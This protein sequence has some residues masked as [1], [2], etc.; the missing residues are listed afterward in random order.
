MGKVKLKKE[1][2]KINNTEYEVEK[3]KEKIV[4]CNKC[5]CE[6]PVTEIDFKKSMVL[7]EHKEQMEINYFI[8]PECD[9]IY[10][11]SFID[12]RARDYLKQIETLRGKIDFKL[13][14]NQKNAALELNRKLN[15]IEADFIAYQKYLVKKYER[16]ITLKKG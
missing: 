3:V 10:Y 5:G 9:E 12:R 16:F 1:N 13:K 2:K 8:C 11:I 6:F 4:K 15:K 7:N 14:I